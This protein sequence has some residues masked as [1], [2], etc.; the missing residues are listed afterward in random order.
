[1]DLFG[2]NKTSIREP[3]RVMAEIKEKIAL[4]ENKKQTYNVQERLAYLKRMLS[5][6]ECNITCDLK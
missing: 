5:I 6:L 2:K 4:L 3:T 1:M